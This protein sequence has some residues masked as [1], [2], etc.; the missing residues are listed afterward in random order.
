MKYNTMDFTFIFIHFPEI[1]D[2]WSEAYTDHNNKLNKI[3]MEPLRNKQVFTSSH[4][5]V[6]F[7]Y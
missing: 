2:N 1:T 6:L 5:K 4:F 7:L 3:D